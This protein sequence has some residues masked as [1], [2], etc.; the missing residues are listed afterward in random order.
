MLSFLC[1]VDLKTP[2]LAHQNHNKHSKSSDCQFFLITGHICL[3]LLNRNN[4][5]VF[6]IGYRYIYIDYTDIGDKF[7][8]F[9]PLCL[10]LLYIHLKLDNMCMHTYQHSQC[11]KLQHAQKKS[12]WQSQCQVIL[13]LVHIM[14]VCRSCEL[15]ILA[16]G[17]SFFSSS[18]GHP[19]FCIAVAWRAVHF[20]RTF[21]TVAKKQFI[22][23]RLASPQVAQCDG[24]F[25]YT[26]TH[27][28]PLIFWFV[29]LNEIPPINAPFTF[30]GGSVWCN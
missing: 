1:S 21:F 25:V 3:F 4:P 19:V 11:K 13:K 26:L 16:F 14:Y 7:F 6:N 23:R 22:T 20:I 5:T 12:K 18:S 27:W 24:I 17:A 2:L 9:T 28:M 8:R 15:V 10:C 30:L 29:Q